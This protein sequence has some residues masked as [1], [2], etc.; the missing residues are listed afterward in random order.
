M[1]CPDGWFYLVEVV[2][3]MA[4][5]RLFEQ[6]LVIHFRFLGAG[7]QKPGKRFKNNI[8]STFVWKLILLGMVFSGFWQ[9]SI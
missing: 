9:K 1:K 3:F 4:W 7:S 8:T 2:E 6:F 5:K